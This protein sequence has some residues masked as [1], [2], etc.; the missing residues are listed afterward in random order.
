[1]IAQWRWGMDYCG[2]LARARDE[3][4]VEV[5]ELAARGELGCS[6]ESAREAVA[7]GQ[8]SPNWRFGEMLRRLA[9]TPMGEYAKPLAVLGAICRQCTAEAQCH[10]WLGSGQTTGNEA[11]CPNATALE[12]L[13]GRR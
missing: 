4:A 9:I 11:F 7:R 3:S 2:R 12:K 5:E 6:V 13:A 1:M 8:P 10:A